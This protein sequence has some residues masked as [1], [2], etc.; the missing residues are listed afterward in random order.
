[1]ARGVRAAARNS[2]RGGGDGLARWFNWT[3]RWSARRREDEAAGEGRYAEGMTRTSAGLEFPEHHAVQ[4]QPLHRLH[5]ALGGDDERG[6][7][8]EPEHID[9]LR[10]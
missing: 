10:E 9:V 7:V 1:V 5:H 3:K 2:G 8:G 4:L 6:P